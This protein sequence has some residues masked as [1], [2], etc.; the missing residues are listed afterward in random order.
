MN[1]LPVTMT[2]SLF[3]HRKGHLDGSYLQEFRI[4]DLFGDFNFPEDSDYGIEIRLQRNLESKFLCLFV[5]L[6]LI[7]VG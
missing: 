2:I 4:T 5:F 1:A 7:S 3:V 6:S